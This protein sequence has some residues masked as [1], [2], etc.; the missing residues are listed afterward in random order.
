MTV[1]P[2]G[3]RVGLR[4]LSSENDEP[5]DQR[6]T[7]SN[8][9]DLRRALL[10][11][12]VQ[13]ERGA[14]CA[15]VASS[16]SQPFE[17]LLMDQRAKLDKLK[18][19]DE[20]HTE[21]L[22]IRANASACVE[23]A[24]APG[25][26][27]PPE[28]GAD[29]VAF[30]AAF[31]RFNKLV[32]TML[33]TSAASVAPGEN[34]SQGDLRLSNSERTV[35]HS[36]MRL[37]EATGVERAF[38]C[39]VLALPPAS[40][41]HLPSR[42]FAEFVMGMQQQEFHRARVMEAAPPSMMGRIREAV[43]YAPELRAIQ[44]KL[45]AEFDV[46]QLRQSLTAARAWQLFTEHI[47]KLEELEQ[48]LNHEHARL[49]LERD[50][51]EEGAAAKVV[52]DLLMLLSAPAINASPPHET[53]SPEV[54]HIPPPERFV[55]ALEA[56]QNLPAEELKQ[57]LGQQLANAAGVAYG[58]RSPLQGQ[59]SSL[60]A[61]P[62]RGSFKRRNRPAAAAATN[63]GTTVST[64]EGAD[65]G[66][67]VNRKDSFEEWCEGIPK[68]YRLGLDS[69]ALQRRIGAGSAGIM[70][71]AIYQGSAVALKLA[72]GSS[73]LD[74]WRRETLAFT[75]LHHPNI[76]RCFG[77]VVEPPSYGMVLEYC[78]FGDMCTVQR[79]G[80]PP[81]FVM[82]VGLGVAAG[83]V[84]LHQQGVLH[85]DLKGV[86]VLIGSGGEAKVTDFGLSTR[87]PD[88]T[89]AGGW[90]TA[91][92]GTYR[93]MAP[94]VLLHERYSKGADVFSYGGVLF[95]L[96]THEAPFEDRPSLQAAVAVGMNGERPPLPVDTPPRFAALVN[97]CW[98]KEV[99]SRPTFSQLHDVLLGLMADGLTIEQRQWLDEPK[100]HPVYRRRH[101]KAQSLGV[102]LATASSMPPV[103]PMPP[104][105]GA[106][107][108]KRGLGQ[109]DE[110]PPNAPLGAPPRV[111]PFVRTTSPAQMPSPISMLPDPISARAASAAP[112]HAA[113][114]H[115][116]YP[117][118]AAPVPPTSLPAVACA[119]PGVQ[120][121][122]GGAYLDAMQMEPDGCA[123]S[124]TNAD[125][126]M[127][128]GGLQ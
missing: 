31:S 122:M 53:T 74:A 55:T 14:T 56:L 70:Y 30:W 105:P 96:I 81:G 18:M 118:A 72:C 21:L 93:W 6:L 57:E 107:N 5:N 50:Q 44:A 52:R 33:H 40:L 38:L 100:G 20:L 119:P 34:D 11:H 92:T 17:G 117:A 115:A 60:L 90:L 54:R 127:F 8:S 68:E 19:A 89:C 82:R 87:A 98:Q 128:A 112:L 37:K 76:V 28:A 49:Q 111:S 94:E 95:E 43:A 65:L 109:C 51:A 29:A 77:L 116:G 15:W 86:N 23:S 32:K 26:A 63:S 66:H 108:L 83:M 62:E 25:G 67:G 45:S 104:L 121:I 22:S 85:R 99:H 79:R 61:S 126:W 91:E 120:P 101:A 84:H 124:S 97:T 10:I 88:D 123:V 114:S 27:A 3:S 73:G 110:T 64:I 1:P 78:E 69:L 58:A 42:A 9:A 12:H 113:P 35:C 71:L 47:D 7:L 102:P 2:S 103:P 4:R 39:G 16:G 24:R 36:F 75:H 48:H 46:L 106:N 13:R 80:T 125:D 59:G 41:S